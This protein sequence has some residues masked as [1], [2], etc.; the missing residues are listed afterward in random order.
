MLVRSMRIFSIC[1]II[2]CFIGSGR[3]VFAMR[4]VFHHK[5]NI[6]SNPMFVAPKNH[7]VNT[8]VVSKEKNKNPGFEVDSVADQKV[9]LVTAEPWCVTVY[10]LCAADFQFNY[11]KMSELARSLSQETQWHKI[12][13]DEMFFKVRESMDQIKKGMEQLV[14]SGWL[15][16][17]S[18]KDPVLVDAFQSSQERAVDA[19]VQV[20]DLLVSHA[21]MSRPKRF[22]MDMELESI[23]MKATGIR[24]EL[25][26]ISEEMRNFK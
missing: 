26:V 18:I 7:T 9:Q 25:Q 23:F 2:S 13:F 22:A 1:L 24:V 16:D 3:G 17:S 12:D 14:R 10:Q 20:L 21:A 11:V 15:L 19:I 5:K 4:K 6:P 8:P